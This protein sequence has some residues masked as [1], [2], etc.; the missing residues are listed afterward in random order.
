MGRGYLT[1]QELTGTVSAAAK[2]KKKKKMM[3]M[4][5]MMMTA[6]SYTLK[7]TRN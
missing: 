7:V 3:M 4:M 5:I 6:S 1:S 2:K